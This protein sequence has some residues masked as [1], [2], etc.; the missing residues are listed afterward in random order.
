MSDPTELPDHVSTGFSYDK[1]E[2]LCFAFLLLPTEYSVQNLEYCYYVIRTPISSDGGIS[3]LLFAL[4]QG[5]LAY[6]PTP[7]TSYLIKGTHSH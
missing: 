7:S 4:E 5:E 1:Q 3:Y 6:R 2:S